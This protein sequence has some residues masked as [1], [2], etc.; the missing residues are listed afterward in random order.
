MNKTGTFI[1]S[2]LLS[3]SLKKSQVFATG[4]HFIARTIAP[5]PHNA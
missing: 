2:K 1:Y 5:P 3:G 4:L